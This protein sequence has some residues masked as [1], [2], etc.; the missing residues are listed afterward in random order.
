MFITD[1]VSLAS[2]PGPGA[3]RPLASMALLMLL[4]L[5]GRGMK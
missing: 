4:W 1:S 5:V 2:F 3:V